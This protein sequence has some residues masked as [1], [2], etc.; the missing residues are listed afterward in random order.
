MK[1][2]EYKN[3]K[4]K[5]WMLSHFSPHYLLQYR[6]WQMSHN[7]AAAAHVTAQFGLSLVDSLYLKHNLYWLSSI[8]FLMDSMSYYKKLIELVSSL[9]KN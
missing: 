9:K 1:I 6:I 5:T 7:R 4:K 2:D 8:I 3:N